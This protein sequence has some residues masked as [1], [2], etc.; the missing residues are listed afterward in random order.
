MAA[1]KLTKHRLAQILITLCL[2][3]IA[4][5]WRT[6]TYTDTDSVK[7]VVKPNCSIFVNGQKITVTKDNKNGQVLT[8]YPS[9]PEWKFEYN[10]EVISTGKSTTLIPRNNNL[11]TPQTLVINET[12]KIQFEL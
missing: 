7:C 6:L 9:N 3:V 8:I 1:E 11:N 10:G 12:V 4:F 5:F 2:L